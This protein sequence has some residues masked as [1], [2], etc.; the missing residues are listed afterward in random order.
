MREVIQRHETVVRPLE[1]AA[2]RAGWAA[3]LNGTDE[4]YR[5]KEELETRL[6]LLLA[7]PA[8]F[9]ELKAIH[10]HP[11]ADPLLR[12]EIE[13]LYREY[14][15]KQVDAELLK[16]MLAEVELWSGRSTSFAR[17]QWQGVD[18]QRHPPRAHRVEGFRPAPGCLGSQQGG[19]PPSGPRLKELAK[20]R[21]E[22]ARKLGF[23]DYHVMQLYLNEQD[24]QEVLSCSTSWTP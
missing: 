10:E 23:K 8:A 19:R 11:P 3:N 4:N 6:D 2:N 7:D 24:Q 18:R 1:I 16:R 5:K 21:N 9:A 22:S 14:L 13:V 15:P 12:R 20:L 17:R